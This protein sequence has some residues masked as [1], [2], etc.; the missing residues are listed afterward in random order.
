MLLNFVESLHSAILVEI[1]VQILDF[2]TKTTDSLD[3]LLVVDHDADVFGAMLRLHSLKLILQLL[4]HAIA[5]GH[6][7]L[8]LIVDVRVFDHVLRPLHLHKV[9]QVVVHFALELFMVVN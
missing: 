3:K 2:F 8:R 4:D 6:L 5:V 1:F 7:R 9:E